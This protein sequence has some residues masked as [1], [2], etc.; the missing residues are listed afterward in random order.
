MLMAGLLETFHA[1]PP[2]RAGMP[3]A[4]AERFVALAAQSFSLGIRWCA[5]VLASL[6]VANLA[7][8]LV[9]R[10]LPQLNV[11]AVGLGMNLLLT[12]GV[13]ALAIGGSVWVFQ[14]QLEPAV[15]KLT[16]ALAPGAG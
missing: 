5:P 2:G 6:L 9:S 4:A 11:L 13:L 16:E 3:G 15:R 1:V 14:D 8:G 10:A 7:L 12:L